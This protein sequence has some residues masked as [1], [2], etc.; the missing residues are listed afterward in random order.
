MQTYLKLLSLLL[1]EGELR[2]DRTGTGTYSVFGE[3]NLVHDM[4]TGFPLLTTKRVS[5][6]NIITELMWFMR[7]D[8]NLKFL[9]DH[10]CHIWDEWADEDGNLGPV[11]GKQWRDAIGIR[12][13]RNGD[14]QRVRIDQIQELVNGLIE[15][16]DSR[17]H[18]V[19]A[20]NPADI[21]RM[22]LPPCHTLFQCYVHDVSNTLLTSHERRLDL[23]LFA[24]SI[25]C[26]LGLPYNVASY[27][28]LLMMLANTC[29]YKPGKLFI[30]FGDLHLYANHV[31]QA[32]LQ[33]SRDPHP[34]PKVWL[35]GARPGM[36]M[37]EY[38]HD[39]FVL[40][41]YVYHPAIKAP[42]AV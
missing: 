19:S 4:A 38:S 3:C 37:D 1:S 35:H 22:A 28:L 25:D 6:R 40:E 24:R 34:L 11:Y 32:R 15:K 21:D 42:I 16:P 13:N 41:D 39:H 5:I 17:R 26:F 14:L 36:P 20:W 8:T 27:A 33:L 30:T 10:G 12:S 7:G 2:T 29:G 31:E 18:I 23:K 9:H